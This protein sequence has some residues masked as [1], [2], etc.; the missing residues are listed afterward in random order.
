MGIKN[1]LWDFDGVILDSMKVRD[2]GF[3]EIFK[4][5]NKDEVDKLIEYHRENGGLSRYVKIRYF[6][7]NILE[8]PIKKEE[9]LDYAENFSLLMKTKLTDKSNLIQ[10]SVR[11]IQGK[12]NDYNFHIVSGSDQEE[13]RFLCHELDLSKFFLSIHGSPTAKK[14]LVKDLISN[15]NYD[16]N[17]TILIGDSIN[18]YDAAVK[19]DIDFYG[20][21]EITLD[22]LSKFYIHDFNEFNSYLNE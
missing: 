17:K 13:L 19:N 22:N 7:E 9:V 3:R 2:W 20:Y 15:F 12:F 6:Y 8:R 18:D 11:F 21:N 1:I 10:D 5:F 16:K 14:T 4:K